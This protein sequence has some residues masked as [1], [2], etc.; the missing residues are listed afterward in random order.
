M[1]TLV[2]WLKFKVRKLENV[3]TIQ[4]KNSYTKII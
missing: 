1:T 3:T 4:N 2:E